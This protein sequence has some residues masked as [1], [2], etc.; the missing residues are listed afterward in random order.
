[1]GRATREDDV[2]FFTRDELIEALDGRAVL[3][4]ETI[5]QRRAGLEAWR[6]V[7]PPPVLGKP[8]SDASSPENFTDV[9]PR[10][11]EVRVI[12]GVGASPGSH[13]GRAR[14]VNALA[15]AETL[16]PGD[17]LVT[18]ATTPAWT[19]FFGVVSA[20]VVNVGGLL[21]HASVVAREF[22]LP[23]VVGTKDGT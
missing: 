13:R 17:I 19:P 18:R 14:V 10:A 22:G 5:A 12:R 6:A 8:S 7:S 16:E 4:P 1:M 9:L 2:F 11:S 20:L 23:A 3:S 21:S 15:E